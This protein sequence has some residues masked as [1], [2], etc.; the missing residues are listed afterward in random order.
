MM[1]LLSSPPTNSVAGSIMLP[2]VLLTGRI[3]STVVLA[4]LMTSVRS[5]NYSSSLCLAQILPLATAIKLASALIALSVRM[6][7]VFQLAVLV[8][9]TSSLRVRFLVDTALY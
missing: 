9:S 6:P 4:L 3:G 1:L 7:V 5:Y 2:L 8:G